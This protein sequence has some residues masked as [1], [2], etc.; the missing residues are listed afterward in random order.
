[1]EITDVNRTYL[2]R[3]MLTVERIGRGIAWLDT[4]NPD[5]LLQA[6]NFVRIVELRQ[7][8]KIACLE[9]V[10]LNLGYID[11]DRVLAQAKPI[12]NT[13]Y[14]QYLLQLAELRE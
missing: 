2:E 6:A 7:G 11:I 5:T 1:L 9:E 10:A 13:E 14:G 12:A 4:G 3:G 8:L